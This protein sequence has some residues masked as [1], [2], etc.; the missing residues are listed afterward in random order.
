MKSDWY[1]VQT[2]VRSEVKACANLER[3]GFTTYFPRYSKRRRHAR[4]TE[5]VTAPLFPRYLFVKAETGLHRWRSINGTFGVSRIVEFGGEPACIDSD[6]VNGIR[7]R[8]CEGLV[9]LAPQVRT[10]AAVRFRDGAFYESIGLVEEAD[11]ERRVLVLL[12][13]LGR[14]VRVNVDVAALEAI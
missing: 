9:V 2:L 11:D 6:I 5:I 14:K 7:S 13:I 4:R 1:V 10:G 3:Q 12:D 8:E